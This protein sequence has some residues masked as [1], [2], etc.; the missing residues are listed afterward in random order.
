MKANSKK[1]TAEITSALAAATFVNTTAKK[2]MKKID[3]TAKK[4]TKTI[5]KKMDATAKKSQ[6]DIVKKEQK[7]K[8]TAKKAAPKKQIEPAVPS[9]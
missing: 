8:T 6:K 7:Q 9:N 5:T 2:M 1:M 4:M 3:A